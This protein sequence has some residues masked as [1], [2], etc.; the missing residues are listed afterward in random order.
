MNLTQ[1]SA[2]ELLSLL[3]AKDV[4]AAEVVEAHLQAIHER[5][6][7]LRAIAV[8][9][10]ERALD[11]AAAIDRLRARGHRAGPLAGLPVTVKECFDLAGTPTTAGV[12][13]LQRMPSG[14]D[15]AVVAALRDA[16]AVIIAKT[17][18]A[19]LCWSLE[20][21]NPVYGRTN[22]P[23]DP[24]R[25]PGG[26]SGGEG[27]A[28]SAR[29]SPVGI[30][31]DSG[32]SVRIPAH[33]CGI[34]ALKPTSGR[35]SSS[36]TVDALL[37]A[38]QPAVTNQP[39]VLARHVEDLRL[40]YELLAASPKAAETTL[41]TAARARQPERAGGRDAGQA[42]AGRRRCVVGFFV[43]GLHAPSAAVERALFQAVRE[44]ESAG[45]VVRPFDPPSLELVKELF[46]AAF[47]LDG[48]ATLRAL[49][50]SSELDPLVEAAMSDLGT[51]DARKRFR[52]A[53][54]LLAACQAYRR[55]FA[56]ALDDSGAD[57][58]VCPPTGVVAHPHGLSQALDGMPITA[59]LFNLLGMPAGIV[60]ISRVQRDE[61]TARPQPVSPVEQAAAAA[62]R[63]SAGLPV[64]VQVAGRPW[65]EAAVLEVMELLESRFRDTPA[66]PAAPPMAAEA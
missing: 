12:A 42:Q 9:R 4:A 31:T 10:F 34:H 29:L 2:T 37:L 49:A 41:D 23:W 64:A 14:G 15:A 40:V 38:F 59:E 7:R 6:R 51:P 1:Q 44:L 19:Q 18:L 33:Y 39:G 24:A 55:Q 13:R 57:V 21:S 46:D 47:T 53:G 20:T 17:N 45:M 35:L 26:S 65:D 22:N 3:E 48:G 28:V 61:E 62:D 58:L 66:Y 16:G 27:A 52:A 43:R 60:S 36:G 54:P 56:R 63:G 8:P 5:D 11:E 32:G 50:G 30:G 25:T